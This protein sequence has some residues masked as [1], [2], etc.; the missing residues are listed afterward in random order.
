MNWNDSVKAAAQAVLA[1]R[2]TTPARTTADA[3]FRW[4]AYEVWLSRVQPQRDTSARTSMTDPVAQ[5]RQDTRA[6]R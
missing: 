4:N 3:S 1:E 5:P 6:E 2:P